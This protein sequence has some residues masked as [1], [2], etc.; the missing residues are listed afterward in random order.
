MLELLY[1]KT[2]KKKVLEKVRTAYSAWKRFKGLMF[3]K[4]ENFDF[5][6]VF[7]F[8]KDEKVKASLHMLF[9]GF[10]I[11]VLFLNSGKRVI[12]KAVLK[13]WL[14]NFTPRQACKFVIEMP[15]QKGESIS[16][17]DFLEW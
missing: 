7:P 3:E 13:P 4:P 6:L 12:E 2:R 16:V 10:P 14:L 15:V 17:G 1:N 9:V 11:C 8:S 5:A